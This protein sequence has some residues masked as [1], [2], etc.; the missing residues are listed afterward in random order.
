ALINLSLSGDAK[1]CAIQMKLIEKLPSKTYTSTHMKQ[2]ETEMNELL[3]SLQGFPVKYFSDP[4]SG[5]NFNFS[6]SASKATW[7]G[8]EIPISKGQLQFTSEQIEKTNNLQFSQA[9]ES[10]TPWSK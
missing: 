10:V 8:K 9:P 5:L 4:I 2:L 7:N 3:F 1:S 6:G